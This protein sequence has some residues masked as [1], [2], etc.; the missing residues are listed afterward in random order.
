MEC[1]APCILAMLQ[2]GAHGAIKGGC[3][4]GRVLACLFSGPKRAQRQ[5]MG[6]FADDVG[7]QNSII[8]TE[9][10]T[11]TDESR[12]KNERLRK[13]KERQNGQHARYRP[14]EVKKKKKTRC[15]KRRERDGPKQ[16]CSAAGHERER[17]TRG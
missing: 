16:Q 4:R 2:F 13:G 11:E 12:G 9:K 3:R 17:A 1:D 8:K 15:K 10:W 7:G 14:D 5:A 6:C